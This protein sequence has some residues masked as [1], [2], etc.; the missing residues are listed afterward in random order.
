[1]ANLG[2]ND[3]KNIAAGAAILGSGGGGSYTDALNVIAELSQ[4]WGGTVPVRQYD[5]ETSSC[6][7]AMLGSPDAGDTL[8]VADIQYAIANTVQAVE[9]ATGVAL[10]CVVPGEIG[11]LSSLIPLIAATMSSNAITW[12]VDGDGAGRAV[13]ELEQTTYSGAANLEVSPA[14]LGND[15]APAAGIQSAILNAPTAAQIEALARG[16]VSKSFGNLAGIAAWPSNASNA[17]AL[18]GNYI[19]GTLTQ[20]WALGQYMLLAPSPPSTADLVTQIAGI[21]GR[22]T[23][24]VL[25][26]FYITEV[27]Q[28]TAGG[29]DAGIVRLDNTPDQSTSTETHYLYNLNESLIMYSSLSSAPDIIAPDS[30]C[31]YSES[32][33]R[34]FSNSTDDLANY[35]GTGNTVSVIKINAAAQLYNANGVVASFANLLKNIGYAGALPAA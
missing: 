12:V 26:N 29:F 16:I 3:F 25:T 23:T 21:T 18:S 11:P 7:L 35:L 30:I 8:T 9:S 34:G 10:A 5:G 4:S 31:Y 27:T 32:T 14:A 28:S 1:M 6:M 19:P 2:I 24:P 20:A 15:A 33:G 17:Y 13:P 22:I